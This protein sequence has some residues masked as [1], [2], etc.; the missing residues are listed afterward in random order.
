MEVSGA[1]R[2]MLLGRPFGVAFRTLGFQGRTTEGTEIELCQRFAL[3][4][5]QPEMVRPRRPTRH[6]ASSLR[7]L[8]SAHEQGKPCGSR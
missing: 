4:N 8:D 5:R 1:Y 6:L 3:L 2:P 7:R